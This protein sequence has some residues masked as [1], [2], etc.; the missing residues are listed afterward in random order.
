MSLNH[1]VSHWVASLKAGESSATQQLWTRY[2]D[3]LVEL[4]RR[5]LDGVPKRTADED[6][7]AQSVFFS[8]CRGATAGRFEQVTD[9]DELWWLLLALTRRKVVDFIRRE[10]AQKRGAGRVHSEQ[11][12][13]GQSGEG[14]GGIALDQMM[15]DDPTPDFLV[16]MEEQHR[17]LLS[18]LRDDRLREIAEAR[19]E[20]YSVLEIASELS[21]STRSVERKLRLIREAWTKE[22]AR[23]D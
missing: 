14:L 17:R 23:A 12:D 7:V 19:I 18:L 5:R 4:A 2:K 20:G 9:R 10:N 8:L 11:T 21:V 15:G 1:S 13:A 6:D 3:R 16:M 22:L